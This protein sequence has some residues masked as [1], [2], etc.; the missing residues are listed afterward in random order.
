[1]VGIGFR[2]DFSK[3]FLSSEILQPDFV[4]VAPE[5]WI[6][7]GGFWK[8]QLKKVTDKYPL[9]TH[10]L[11]L[12]IGSPDELDVDFVKQ[13][14]KFLEEQNVVLYSE[15]LSFT[16]AENAHTYDLL[17]IPFT[18]QAIEHVVSKIQQAQDILG[19]KLIL[20]NASYYTTLKEEMSESEFIHE[21]IQKSGCE[22]LLD[23][24]NVYVNA[25]NHSY[26]AKAFIS[27]LPLEKVKY[28]HMAGHWKVND[29]LIIDTHGE[30]IIDPVYELL[31]FTMK[32]LGRDVP[33]LLE[34]DF[35]IPQ[36]AELQN[37]I[38][39]IRK[40][41]TNALKSISHVNA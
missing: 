26:D 20:E 21:I 40:I 36:L 17:P 9:Y 34:R 39:T 16:K 41:K 37:E 33:V 31:D 8:Q 6:G 27:K 35:N 32:E 14:K 10:G 29:K 7:I 15:H 13:V 25:F 23:V 19:R 24:N 2:K 11:S 12:S 3:E 5:N 4:E 1:M 28:I 18:K 38:N 22:M 30:A